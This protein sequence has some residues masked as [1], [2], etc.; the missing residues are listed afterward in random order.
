MWAWLDHPNILR[1]FGITLDPLQVVTEWVPD[2]SVVEYVK[3][4]RD[5][6][7]VCLVSS[8][9]RP[10]QGIVAQHPQIIVGGRGSGN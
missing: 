7:R 2:G 3:T 8:L 4:H 1:C 10:T 6:D 5:A 9:A